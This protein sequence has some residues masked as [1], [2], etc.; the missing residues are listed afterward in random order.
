VRPNILLNV[1][2]VLTLKKS[3]TNKNSFEQK[4][5]LNAIINKDV[6]NHIELANLRDELDMLINNSD[7][8]S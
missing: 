2:L 1:S 6:V 3:I 4:F 7:N 8:E 5:L